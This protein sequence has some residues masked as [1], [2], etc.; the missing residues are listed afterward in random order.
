MRDKRRKSTP[1][2]GEPPA[3]AAAELPERW[4]AGS[5]RNVKCLVG[6]VE[7]VFPGGPTLVDH[8]IHS[9]LRQLSLGA[10][11]LAPPSSTLSR[12]ALLKIS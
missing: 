7:T 4:S 6:I 11:F 9:G 5:R 10:A 8:L 3:V 2:G 12:H 1:L